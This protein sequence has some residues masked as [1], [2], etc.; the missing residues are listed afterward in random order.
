MS[1]VF[2]HSYS[3]SGA[4][5]AVFTLAKEYGFYDEVGVEVELVEYPRTSDALKGAL[6]REVD[7]ATCPGVCILNEAMAGHDPVNVM[8]MEDEN[9]FGMIGAR[10]IKTPADLKGTTIGTFGLGDQNQ[11][12]ISRALTKLGL[13]PKSDVEFKTDYPDRAALLAAVDAGEVSAICFTVP[14]PLMARRMGLPILL[15]FRD[16]PEPYQCGA[17]VTS[18]RYADENPETLVRFL[19][20]SMKGAKLFQEDIEAALP[21]LAACSKLDDEGVLREVHGLFAIALRTLTPSLPPLRGVAT[22]LEAALGRPLGVD[23]TALVDDSFVAPAAR[24]A[25]R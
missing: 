9:V 21:H 6:R 25:K 11:V 7:A 17:V 1:P 24:L 10:H 4:V 14:T 3:N 18:R 5:N 22:D 2:R 19:A 20:G 16:H 15:D 12:V 13:D 23:L 8:N